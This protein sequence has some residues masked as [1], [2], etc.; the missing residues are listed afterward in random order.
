M[1]LRKD[2]KTNARCDL[3]T[4]RFNNICGRAYINLLPDFEKLLRHRTYRAG[5]TVVEEGEFPA[6]LGNVVSGTLRE[7]RIEADG[8]RQIV[9]LLMPTDMF[10]HP[11]AGALPFSLEAATDATLCCI[12]T[13]AFERKTISHPI[14]EQL[15][16]RVITQELARSREWIFMLGGQTVAERLA[17][18]LLMIDRRWRSGRGTAVAGNDDNRIRMP[19]CR[20]DM[21]A[22]LGTTVE[23]ISR[24]FHTLAKQNMVSTPDRHSVEVLDWPR[25]RA[26]AGLEEM[27]YEENG[28]MVETAFAQLRQPRTV[29]GTSMP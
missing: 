27:P 10:G 25:L 14:L 18:F 6:F 5:E 2:L 11:Y 28:R 8:R 22:C 1:R 7:H 23:S 13:K 9:G 3:C 19:V 4:V 17:R 15:T 26:L 12:D 16:S 20:R 29:G 24:T 21:A